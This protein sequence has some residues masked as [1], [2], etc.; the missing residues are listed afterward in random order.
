MQSYKKVDILVWVLNQ[1]KINQFISQLNNLEGIRLPVRA[2]S[3]HKDAIE[4]II[5]SLCDEL[6][7]LIFFDPTYGQ[8]PAR[9]RSRNHALVEHL[10]ILVGVFFHRVFL[11]EVKF[12]SQ[13]LKSSSF[14]CNN[15][16]KLC[17]VF[18]IMEFGSTISLQLI[19]DHTIR[20]KK[21]KPFNSRHK[22][23]RAPLYPMI[24]EL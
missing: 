14:A 21:H 16:V 8:L 10:T 13:A 2:K 20:I 17:D 4:I 6:I 12:D 15:C 3:P 1:L 22:N 9:Y 7:L 11:V 23:L 24:D 18:S 19:L 5:V